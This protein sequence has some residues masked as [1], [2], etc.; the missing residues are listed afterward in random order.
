MKSLDMLY[1]MLTKQK[2]VEFFL[3]TH[4]KK[5]FTVKE[6]AQALEERGVSMTVAMVRTAVWRGLKKGTIRKSSVRIS[7]RKDHDS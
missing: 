2:A 1:S 4:K 5:S 3:E 7:W 6:I